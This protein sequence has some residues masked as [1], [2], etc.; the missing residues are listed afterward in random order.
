MKTRQLA[1]GLALLCLPC[2]VWA[3]QVASRCPTLPSASGLQWVE[4]ASVGFI[5]CKARSP[6]G[7]QSL[8]LMLTSRDPDIR[9]LRSQRTESG[10]FS[11]A[12]FHWYIP[13]LVGRADEYAASRRITV[14]K[15]GK[16]QYAQIWIDAQSPE[17]LGKLQSMVS[18]MDAS[19]GTQYLVSGK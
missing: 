19:A 17:A 5:A 14:L 18:Q 15:L 12:A 13:E 3:Q 7:S 11:G 2:S 6:D 4:K 8:N 1:F 16:D 10:V 9:L